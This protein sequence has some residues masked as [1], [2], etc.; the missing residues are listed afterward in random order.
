MS[1]CAVCVYDLHEEALKAHKEAVLSLQNSLS[2]LHIPMDEWPSSIRQQ[3]TSELSGLDKRK[4]MVLNAFEEM[5][6]A[7]MLKRQSEAEA[8]ARS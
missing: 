3:D 1:G 4:E 8:Q 5:E 7:L 6:R 2:A